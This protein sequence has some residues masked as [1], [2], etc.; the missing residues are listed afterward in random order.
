MNKY[1]TTFINYAFLIL[2]I[3]LTSI[4][5]SAIDTECFRPY[6]D[7]KHPRRCEAQCI[8]FLSQIL[9]S[10]GAAKV[11]CSGYEF[12]SIY[13]S[14]TLVE[15]LKIDFGV[16][17]RLVENYSA[18]KI[19]CVKKEILATP[20]LDPDAALFKCSQYSGHCAK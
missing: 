5:A 12:K 6:S 18:D 4:N 8:E 16:A 20:S 7:Q 9:D 11:K 19:E 13:N 1:I 17:L 15:E 3:A 10:R 2:S 14:A